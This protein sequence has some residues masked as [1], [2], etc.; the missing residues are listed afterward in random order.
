[1]GFRFV[2]LILII[3]ISGCA[4][5]NTDPVS[6]P[7][8]ESAGVNVA[9][10]TISSAN[11]QPSPALTHSAAVGTREY[12]DLWQRIRDGFAL[13]TLS[14]KYVDY[15]RKWYVQRPHY[16]ARL[17]DRAQPYLFYIV[18]EIEKRGM[19]TEIAL[20]P[21]IESAYKPTAYSRAH[22]SGLWQFIPSTASRY[23]LKMS[24]WYDGRRDVIAATRAALDYLQYLHGEFE[25]N[26]F[27]ALA[28]YNAGEGSIQYAINRNRQR[29]KSTHY[30]HLRLKSETKRYVPKLAA[31]KEI[32]SQPDRFGI[33]LA[34][35][36]NKPFFSSVDTLG[37]IDLH[38]AQDLSGM[39]DQEL[40]LLNPAFKRW[41][42]DPDGP[43]RLLV[44]VAKSVQIKNELAS[45][46]ASARLKWGHYRIKR[47]DTLSQIAR[48][49][50]VSVRAL[51]RSNG[52]KTTFIQ[53]GNDLLV[54]LPGGTVASAGNSVAEVNPF[55]HRVRSGD[56]LWGIARRYNVYVKQLARW[57]SIKT[58]DLLRLG[59]NIVVY[60]N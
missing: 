56:T 41:A 52:L 51:Q 57:N 29:G 1:M 8:S 55:I 40:Q 20:L 14:N 4:T 13:P 49:Y 53:A 10:R 7:S 15:Y 12:T 45:L 30:Q 39:S 2:V 54:P 35:I 19:P 46:P 32:V 11:A 48:K 16:I 43:H 9:P 34:V 37:Q 26:W 38:V 44:P 47:G 60:V 58:N 24:W 33:E 6:T 3:L 17:L 25:G 21:A 22:A 31:L 28:A 27:H 59:Q 50:G 23:G 18:E 5:T 36:P 42:T